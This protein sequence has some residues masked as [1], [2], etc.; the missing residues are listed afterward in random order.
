MNVLATGCRLETL[1]I[2]KNGDYIGYT[3]TFRA[4]TIDDMVDL[5]S[6]QSW[7]L[8]GVTDTKY[9]ESTPFLWQDTTCSLIGALV[10]MNTFSLTLTNTFMSDDLAFQNGQEK[11][12]DYICGSSG[13]LTA[14][15]I[16]DTTH[17]ATVY[18][19]LYSQTCMR[20]VI[21]ITNGLVSWTITTEGQYTDY[22]KPDKENCL[23]VGGFTK[24]LLGDGSNTAIS[25]AVA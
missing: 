22:T 18:D 23:Y 19:N 11:T 24:Q 7:A 25:I 9:P 6:G 14:E 16:Y 4:Q 12:R 13:V 15:W 5:S 1:E 21:T 20:D 8:T 2:S 10:K 3:A 17:D